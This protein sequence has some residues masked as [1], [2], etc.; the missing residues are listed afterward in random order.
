MAEFTYDYEDQ[1][2]GSV[3]EAPDI[4]TLAV[5]NKSEIDQQIT[6]ARRYPRSIKHF[7]NEALQLVTLD[8]QTAQSCI[9]ALPRDG[10]TIEGPSA[11]FAEIINY[12]WGNTRAGARVVGEDEEFVSSQGLFYDLE[13]NTAIAYE[14]KRRITNKSGKR[15]NA[16]MVG[17]T[18]N[19][20]SSIALRNAI[21]KGVPKAL[22][23]P[24]YQAARKVVAGD[25]STLANRRDEAIKAFAIFG[26]KP[27]QIYA[28][29]NV[30]GVEDITIDHLVALKGILTAIQENETTPEQA[31]AS[32]TINRS[33]GVGHATHEKTGDVVNKYV[34]GN[35]GN[36]AQDPTANPQQATAQTASAPPPNSEKAAI[37]RSQ[38]SRAERTNSAPAAQ[39]I[40]GHT[41]RGREPGDDE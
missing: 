20:A 16:D 28:T 27:D 23:G 35:G 15:F 14:V 12:S 13:K 30:R 41:N 9:Y 22:W 36:G 17:T 11:R 38:T 33:E 18:S 40:F 29:L 21:L 34:K 4:G 8:E 25:F 37:S 6:T 19:A 7:K 32:P 39:E 31:F 3:S 24:I 10:K 5:L 1:Q 26:V 2:D